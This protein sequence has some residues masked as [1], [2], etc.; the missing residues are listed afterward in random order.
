MYIT[1]H[2][3]I[4]RVSVWLQIYFIVNITV[5][6]KLSP[7]VNSFRVVVSGRR[8]CTSIV[9][10]ICIS[11]NVQNCVAAFLTFL[12]AIGSETQEGC[13]NGSYNH[14]FG[15]ILLA[16][17]LRWTCRSKLIF[18]KLANFCITRIVRADFQYFHSKTFVAFRWNSRICT[19]PQKFSKILLQ[20]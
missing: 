17:I 3:C 13:Y 12:N 2:L 4:I 20:L 11:A 10:K 5:S 8:R 19:K 7:L 15:K 9:K 1:K 16:T 14:L 18:K 6:R